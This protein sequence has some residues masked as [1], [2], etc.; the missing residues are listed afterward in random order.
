MTVK[1]AWA[2]QA[3][4]GPVR[5]HK[6]LTFFACEGLIALYDER[7]EAEQARDNYEVV[8]PDVFL[9]RANELARLAKLMEKSDL[10]WQRQEGREW[11]RGCQDMKECVKEAKAMGDP[12]DP[13]VQAFWA[14]HRRRT[15]AAVSYEHGK[16]KKTLAQINRDA[17]ST[18][19]TGRE[20]SPLAARAGEDALAAMT[21][22]ATLEGMEAQAKKIRKKPVKKRRDGL[23]LDL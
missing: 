17:P 8:Q 23:I 22:A 9:H 4:T 12:S 3:R 10:R 18:G 15:T 1:P 13:Q 7:D 6:Q 21:Y 11:R 19:R 14:R 20:L 16:P 2:V 5:H